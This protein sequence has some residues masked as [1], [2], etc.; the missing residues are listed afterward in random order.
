M[1]LKIYKMNKQ[2]LKWLVE[3]LKEYAEKS[4][5]PEN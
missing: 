2:A 5:E 1:F 3:M 4:V